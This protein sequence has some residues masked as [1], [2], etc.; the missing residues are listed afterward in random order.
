MGGSEGKRIIPVCD[1]SGSMESAYGTTVAPMDVS[2]SLGLYISER[3]RGPFKNHFI[4]FST[5]PALVEV[6]G[7]TLKER[8]TNLENADWGGSTDL[9]A[10]FKLILAQAQRH[11]L[12]QSDMP[13]VI[14]IIS[15]MEFNSATRT[16]RYG[17]KV[18]PFEEIQSDYAAAGY[19]APKIV[20]W[21]VAARNEGNFPVI[22]DEPNTAL[23]SGFS[24]SI[25]KP[26]LAGRIPNPTDVMLEVLNAPR[27]ASITLDQN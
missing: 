10:V 23:I 14:L 17:Q 20:F 5:Q 13:E 18:T 19:T 15:D 26:L 11:H 21:N 12:A 22:K 6:K 25:L 8:A 1:V 9:N 3:N 24:P 7:N 27:Y 4:T 16:G 2:I